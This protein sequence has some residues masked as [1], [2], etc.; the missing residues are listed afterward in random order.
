MNEKDQKELDDNLAKIM[1]SLET[2]DARDQIV[3]TVLK[4]KDVDNSIIDICKKR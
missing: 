1:R 3:D 2:N 4:S